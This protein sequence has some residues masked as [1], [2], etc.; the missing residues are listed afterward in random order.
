MVMVRQSAARG[1]S[2]ARRRPRS[3]LAGQAAAVLAICVLLA[4]WLVLVA[5]V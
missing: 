3:I 2:A 1:L 4:F 5:H